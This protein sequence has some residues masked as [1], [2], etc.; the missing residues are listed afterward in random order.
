MTRTVADAALMLQVIAGPDER[1]RHTL[2]V[3]GE[4]FAAAASEPMRSRRFAWSPDLGYARL[5]PEVRQL[6]EAAARRFASDL[7]CELEE[8]APGFKDPSDA[9]ERIFY[10][11]IG[12]WGQRAL[13][14]VAR[15]VG[16][17]SRESGGAGASVDRFRHGPGLPRA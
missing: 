7:G 6:A 11:G 4:D 9:I 14:R 5:D 3:S 15:P 13:V 10:G 2:Q 12:S 17:G 1:D 8:M 16:S